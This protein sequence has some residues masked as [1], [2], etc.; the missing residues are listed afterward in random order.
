MNKKIIKLGIITLIFTTTLFAY[1]SYDSGS[2][3]W[4]SKQFGGATVNSTWFRL[5]IGGFYWSHSED[6]IPGVIKYVT[7]I[8]TIGHPNFPGSLQ[9]SSVTQCIDLSG[10]IINN[11]QRNEMLKNY[12]IKFLGSNLEIKSFSN[13]QYD[14]IISDINGKLLINDRVKGNNTYN[15]KDV[16]AIIINIIDKNQKI[17]KKLVRI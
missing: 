5:G 10:N 1:V 9:L 8:Y 7:D 4:Q 17:V 15:L 3:S 14:I 6:V 13:E 12:D 2:D 16:N 11:I